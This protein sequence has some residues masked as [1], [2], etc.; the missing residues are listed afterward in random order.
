M[1]LSAARVIASTRAAQ[2]DGRN[3]PPDRDSC[4]GGVEPQ[5]ADLTI[6]PR[7]TQLHEY[8]FSH[9]YSLCYK[10]ILE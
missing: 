2:I 6:W 10:G 3:L 5:G 4:T 8:G 7:S 9:V 1:V